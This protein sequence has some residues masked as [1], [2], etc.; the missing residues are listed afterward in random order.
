MTNFSNSAPAASP[1]AAGAGPLTSVPEVNAALDAFSTSVDALIANLAALSEAPMC[2]MANAVGSVAVA[3]NTVQQAHET[4]VET[5]LALAALVPLPTPPWDS[6]LLVIA[7]AANSAPAVG[8]FLRSTGPWTADALY[9]VVPQ[10]PLAAVPNNGNKWF[11]ITRGKYVGLTKNAA[12]SLNAVTGVSTGLSEK[13]SSQADALDNFNTALATNAVAVLVRLPPF[14]QNNRLPP[15][16]PSPILLRLL[17]A[18]VKGTILAD[19]IPSLLLGLARHFTVTKANHERNDRFLVM[20]EAAAH[21]QGVAGASPGRLTLKKKRTKTPRGGFAVFCGLETGAFLKWHEVV[22]LVSNV[23][24]SLYQGYDD[25]NLARAAYDY[26]Y[27]R[28]WTRIISPSSARVCPTSSTA[29]P[30]L[31]SPV[32]FVEGP[33]PL[34]GGLAHKGLWYVV[35]CGIHPGVYQ[36]SLEGSLNTLCLSSAVHQSFDSKDEAIRRFQEA[37]GK[38]LVKVITPRYI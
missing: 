35:F 33:N 21:T 3:A 22:P 2:Q 15:F 30:R 31:P 1:A 9:S 8:S 11:A 27:E 24:G 29:I 20:A 23:S 32:G 4:L 34:H 12:I 13:H 17:L 19:R 37:L 7:V 10:A 36:S 6:F 28:G 25:L 38:D 5:V 16:P 18:L 26:A 14:P